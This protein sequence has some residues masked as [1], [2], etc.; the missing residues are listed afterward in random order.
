MCTVLRT[1]T[2][3]YDIADEKVDE[4]AYTICIIAQEARPHRDAFN[5]GSQED[6]GESVYVLYAKF[7]RNSCSKLKMILAGLNS[8]E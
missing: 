7:T 6:E 3:Y 2:Y 8:T 4:I 5:D 1:D